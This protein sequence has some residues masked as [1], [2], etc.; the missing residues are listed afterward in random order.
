MVIIACSAVYS[1]PMWNPVASKTHLQLWE[2]LQLKADP[3]IFP[4]LLHKII[5]GLG[6]LKRFLVRKLNLKGMS[7]PHTPSPE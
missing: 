2:C 6:S 3:L 5:L 1:F 4:S 7:L